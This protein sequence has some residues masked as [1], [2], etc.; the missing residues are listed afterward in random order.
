MLFQKS[1]STVEHPESIKTKKYAH[2]TAKQK[3]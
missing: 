1:Y 2:V 3:N